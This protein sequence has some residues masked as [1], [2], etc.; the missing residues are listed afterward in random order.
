[1]QNCPD[2]NQ[3]V[4]E[5]AKKCQQC[6]FPL[7]E[8]QVGSCLFWLIKIAFCIIVVFVGGILILAIIGGL[9]EKHAPHWL[10]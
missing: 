4:S 1:M 2:C 3:P 9:I 5:Y 10:E 8:Y 7:R 6:G